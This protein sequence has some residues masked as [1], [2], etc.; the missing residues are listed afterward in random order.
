MDPFKLP[1]DHI[2]SVAA[3]KLDWQISVIVYL[4]STDAS[5][6]ASYSK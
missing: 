4:I 2:F 1:S 5:N 6:M 3:G